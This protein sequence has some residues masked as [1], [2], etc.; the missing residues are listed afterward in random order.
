MEKDGYCSKEEKREITIGVR[1]VTAA[2]AISVEMNV[3]VNCGTRDLHTK[4][5]CREWQ[6]IGTLE[7][8]RVSQGGSL[9]PCSL[10]KLACVPLFP[11]FFRSCSLLVQSA[12]FPPRLL[13]NSRLYVAALKSLMLTDRHFLFR[14]LHF[15]SNSKYFSYP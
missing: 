9:F 3:N 4:E 5:S 12:L 8:M 14:Y 7:R 10:Q 1:H 13:L 6:Q 11:Q 15:I 2:A